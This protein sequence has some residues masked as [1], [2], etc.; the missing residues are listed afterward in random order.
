M[1]D[2]L[3]TVIEDQHQEQGKADWVIREYPAEYVNRPDVLVISGI[4]RCG[5]SVLLQQIRARQRE[6]DYFVNFDDERLSDFKAE[7]FQAL[8]EVLIE[9][10]GEQHTFY[11][12]EIQN[13]AGWERFVRR[14]HDEGN[15]IYLTGSNATMLSQELG[16]RLTG[17]Y[18][19]YELYPFSFREFL[20]FKKYEIPKEGIRTTVSRAAG[21]RLF[22]DYLKMGGMPMY[23]RQPDDIT[24]KTIYETIVYRDILVRNQL[25]NPREILEMIYY[26]ASTVSQ[27]TTHTALAKL[28]NIASPTSI[29][30][31]LDA[32]ANTYLIGAV[33]QYDYSV[34]T[35]LRNPKKYYFIDNALVRKLGFRFSDNKGQLL[36]NFVFIELKRR[37]NDL[38]YHQ[39]NRECDFLIRDG[40]RIRQ[41]LQVAYHIDSETT[42]E[43]EQAGIE[44]AMERYH[45]SEGWIITSDMKKEIECAHGTIH[46]VPAWERALSS[47]KR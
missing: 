8:H 20:A 44:E 5:K 47:E 10:F 6:R 7:D 26:L 27:K 22:Y 30:N 3:R 41:A 13:V 23:L 15:K 14:L 40:A 19:R 34:K 32:I 25:R 21:S 28:L 36:E 35:Q 17:R 45:L 16:T 31:Y 11:F 24:L 46:V 29:K 9:R 12:D 4:R 39:G 42:R 33:S 37:Q 2:K 1:K 18:C 43:R 38:Y